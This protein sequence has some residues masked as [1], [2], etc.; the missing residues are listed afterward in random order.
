MVAP[1]LFSTSDLST[2]DIKSKRPTVFL[3]G[4]GESAIYPANL[5]PVNLTG[6]E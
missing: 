2:A 5:H 4:R 1:L 3:T 6:G